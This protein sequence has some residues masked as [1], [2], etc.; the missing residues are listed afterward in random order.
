MVRNSSTKALYGFCAT[1]RIHSVGIIGALLVDPTK[2]NVSIGRSLHRRAMRNLTQKHGIQKVQLG[3]SFPAVFLG[4]PADDSAALKSWFAS[5]GWDTQFPRRLT[6]MVVADV[7]GWTVPE[8]LTQ[9]IA[10]AGINFDLIHGLDNAENVMSHVGAYSN[11]EVLELYRFAL[12]EAKTCGVV[13]AK[14]S[15]GKILGTIIISSPGSSLPQRVPCLQNTTQRELVG[16]VVAPLVEPGAQAT[17]VLQGLAYMG[18]RQNKA[19]KAARSVLS[20][21]TDDLNEPLLAMGFQ[22]LQSFEEITNAPENVRPPTPHCVLQMSLVRGLRSNK[23]SGR[24]CLDIQ[25]RVLVDKIPMVF[26]ILPIAWHI[27]H[28]EA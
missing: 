19:H 21:V 11:V 9:N 17:L 7:G 15:L 26:S 20:W 13:R 24:T 25:L 27:G 5:S 3:T 18:V 2:R 28:W 8:G 4:I 6:N 12:Q 10:R 23:S 14:N 1:Y 16:G 22:V